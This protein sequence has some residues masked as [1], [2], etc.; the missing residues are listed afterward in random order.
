MLNE[1][2]KSERK[3][4]RKKAIEKKLGPR[5]NFPEGQASDDVTPAPNPHG[6]SEHGPGTERNKRKVKGEKKKAKYPRPVDVMR[7]TQSRKGKNDRATTVMKKAMEMAHTV[8]QD[9]GYLMAESLGLVS[10]ADDT[11]AR[12]S[13][14]GKFV[15][16]PQKRKKSTDKYNSNEALRTDL[17]TR[18][19]SGKE[20]IGRGDTADNTIAV[21]RLSPEEVK[22]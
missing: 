19:S 1:S 6:T 7:R 13:G 16:P 15:N 4:A 20:Y 11:R 10:E 21:D 12:D 17:A 22:R 3:A 2:R 8:Y 5:T 9:M 14:V 18:R